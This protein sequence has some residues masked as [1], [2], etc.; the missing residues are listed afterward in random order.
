MRKGAILILFFVTTLFLI[1]TGFGQNSKDEESIPENYAEFVDNM[2]PMKHT[3]LHV[4]N[5]WQKMRGKEVTWSGDVVEAQTKR[6]HRAQVLIADKT[7]PRYRGYNIVLITPDVDAAASF[8]KGESVKFKG[9]IHD[10]RGRR[11]NPLIVTLIDVY[12]IK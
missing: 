1:E 9:V 4:K 10:Y 5:Y 12:F 6:G 2:D 7:K 8:N 11:G 3:D